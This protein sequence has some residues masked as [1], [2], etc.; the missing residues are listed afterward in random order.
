MFFPSSQTSASILCHPPNISRC[1]FLSENNTLVSFLSFH[2]LLLSSA[3]TPC[4]FTKLLSDLFK[5]INTTCHS[6]FLF[7]FIHSF[8]FYSESS[9]HSWPDPALTKPSLHFPGSSPDILSL[10]QKTLAHGGLPSSNLGVK[11]SFSFC[12]ETLLLD[13]LWGLIH[14]ILGF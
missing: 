6:L 7:Y 12:F 11:I 13:L 10:D 4:S 1:Y 5:N 2:L 3:V 14:L 9:Y 8:L